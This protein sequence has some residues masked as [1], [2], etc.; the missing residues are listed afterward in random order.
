MAD[1]KEEKFQVTN[2]SFHWSHGDGAKIR[3]VNH[4]D[5]Y[6]IAVKGGYKG[7]YGQ[8]L[9]EKINLSEP[10]TLPEPIDLNNKPNTE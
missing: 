4:R 7:T 5:F 9:I 1:A 10:L 2:I 6:E 8:W 3:E